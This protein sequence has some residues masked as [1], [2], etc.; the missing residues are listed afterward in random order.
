MKTIETSKESI[1]ANYLDKIAAKRE[2]AEWHDQGTHKIAVAVWF[3]DAMEIKDQ[4]ERDKLLELWQKTPSSF[5]SNA[6]A[7]GQALGRPA[8]KAKLA[9]AFKGF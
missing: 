3:L 2:G 9:E 1:K 6:S 4:G 7:L 5:G 8:A